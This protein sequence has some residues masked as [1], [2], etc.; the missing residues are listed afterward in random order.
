ML[1]VVSVA[2]VILG[3]AALGWGTDSRDQ[4]PDD[5]RR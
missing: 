4:M 1:I 5:Y 2:F 3:L